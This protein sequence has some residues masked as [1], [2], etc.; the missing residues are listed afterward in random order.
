[1]NRRDPKLDSLIGELVT[2]NFRDG[3]IKVGVLEYDVPIIEGISRH[4]YSLY[5]FNSGRLYFKKSH[6]KGISEWKEPVEID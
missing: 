2:V 4:E 1:M 5:I 3:D 6:V